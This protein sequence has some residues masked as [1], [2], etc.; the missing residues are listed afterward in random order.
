M[1]QLTYTQVQTPF[2][3]NPAGVMADNIIN[4]S[5]TASGI[6]PLT[7]FSS[8][9]SVGNW[10]TCCCSAD[11]TRMIVGNSTTKIYTSID[12][13]VTWSEETGS[14]NGPC[15]SIACSADGK[16]LVASYNNPIRRIWTAVDSGS[17]YIW[18]EHTNWPDGD[19]N[20]INV[21]LASDANGIKLAATSQW[22]GGPDPSYRYIYTSTNSGA[23]WARAG[24]SPEQQWYGI[25]SNSTGTE[26]AA[27][28]WFGH[29]WVSHDSGTTWTE[30]Y[31]TGDPTISA[32]GWMD[33]TYS[34]DASVLAAVVFSVTSGVDGTI[35]ISNDQGATWF[36]P[37]THPVL[38]G[39]PKW[40]SITVSP[41]GSKLT[42]VLDAKNTTDYAIWHSYDG[43]INWS[44]DEANPPGTGIIGTAVASSSTGNTVVMVGDSTIWVGT[45]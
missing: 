13:G 35:W 32:G 4:L 23:N 12:S 20:M 11:G 15:M 8:G 17:G 40:Y 41:D 31:P 9:P 16:K 18:T 34:A 3:S 24:N 43:G 27:C 21:H 29:I 19:G 22:P 14:F 42:C 37:T 45:K 7:W 25:T 30:E 36:K 38:S 33:I 26:L 28:V 2:I 39:D 44:A 6:A 1:L 5:I 10:S